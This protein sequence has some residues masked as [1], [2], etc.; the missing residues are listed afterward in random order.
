M[1]DGVLDGCKLV[2]GIVGFVLGTYVGTI[3]GD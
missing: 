2:G 1:K 3:D